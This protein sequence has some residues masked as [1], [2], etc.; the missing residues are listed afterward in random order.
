MPTDSRLWFAATVPGEAAAKAGMMTGDRIVAV[1]TIDTPSYTELA[2]ALLTYAGRETDITVVRDGHAI[3]SAHHPSDG[4]KLG[5]QLTP[6]TDVYPPCR[7]LRLLRVDTARRESR[8]LHPRNYVSS[9]R[10]V[11][12]KRGSQKA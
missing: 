6:L 8:H 5:F 4:G 3:P 11:F 7:K 2:P 9:L 12:F 1:D 10:H